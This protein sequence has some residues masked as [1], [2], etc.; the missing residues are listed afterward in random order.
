MTSALDVPIFRITVLEYSANAFAA[1]NQKE[2]ELEIW[3]E[4]YDYS[5][6]KHNSSGEG[7]ALTKLGT[8]LT[9]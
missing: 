2:K 8:W 4:I 1:V 3:H 9:R 5:D 7:E 6:D